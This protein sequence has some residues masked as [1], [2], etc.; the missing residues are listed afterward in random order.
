MNNSHR[1]DERRLLCLSGVSK[2][3]PPVSPSGSLLASNVA[4]SG[5]SGGPPYTPV[6]SAV[7]IGDT[8]KSAP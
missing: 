1:G 8:Q 3:D 5:V 2:D 7:S 6:L 4:I